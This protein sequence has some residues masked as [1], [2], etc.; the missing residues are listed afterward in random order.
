MLADHRKDFMLR[1]P[2][3]QVKDIPRDIER[4]KGK[5][6]SPLLR[7]PDHDESPDDQVQNHLHAKQKT[8]LEAR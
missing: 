4:F 7:I 5:D 2:P 6:K 8:H 1:A 3:S